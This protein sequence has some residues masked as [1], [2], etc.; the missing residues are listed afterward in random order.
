MSCERESFRACQQ[1]HG[2]QT[3]IARC[4]LDTA[5]EASDTA[6]LDRHDWR[7]LAEALATLGKA[8][9]QQLSGPTFCKSAEEYTRSTAGWEENWSRMSVLL[10]GAWLWTSA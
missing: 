5:W 3:R 6:S 1:G 10:V 7:D 4:A 2:G 8:G 9:F